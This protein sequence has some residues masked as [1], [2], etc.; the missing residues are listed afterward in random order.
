MKRKLWLPIALFLPLG[1]IACGPALR[2]TRTALPP[3][4]PAP[5]ATPA[6]L[7]AADAGVSVERA[8]ISPSTSQAIEERMVT[9]TA[10]L[11]LIVDEVEKTLPEI[12]ALTAQLNGYIVSSSAYRTAT[13]R[14]AAVI[15]IRVPAERYQEALA[16]LRAVARKVEAESLSGEDVTDQYVDL[17]A[18]LKT[19]R[20]TEEELL[21]LLREVRESEG[22]ADQ[23]AQAILSIYNQLTTVRSEIEQIQGQMQYLEKMSAMAT[24][25]VDLRPYEPKVEQP[26]IEEG[27]RPSRTLRAA[28]RALIVVLQW[29]YQALIWVI[30]VFLPVLALVALPVGS[31]VFLILWR[32]RRRKRSG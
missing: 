25:T 28:A 12:Q 18:R 32:Q 24:I 13:D 29:L 31:I 19:L 17:Q 1:L 10:Q 26:V 14:L 30:V 9:S 22:N 15:T 4:Q 11:T 7:P 8:Y 16:H 3:E 5:M 27:F 23:K 2:A 6:P 20:A 21:A